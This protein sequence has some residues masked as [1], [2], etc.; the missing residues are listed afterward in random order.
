MENG[1][2]VVDREQMEDEDWLRPPSGGS[3]EPA[4]H[5]IAAAP[6]QPGVG[7]PGP[8]AFE[9]LPRWPLLVSEV[10]LRQRRSGQ[11]TGLHLLGGCVLSGEG[12]M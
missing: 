5:G 8:L 9:H 11:H 10:F 3:H 12:G 4:H 1:A 7:R 2:V 6:L